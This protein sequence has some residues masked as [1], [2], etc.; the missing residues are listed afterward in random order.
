MDLVF[1]SGLKSYQICSYLF[2]ALTTQKRSVLI[3]LFLAKSILP[4]H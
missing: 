3:S 4:V 1:A 2:I